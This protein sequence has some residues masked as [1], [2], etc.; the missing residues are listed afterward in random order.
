MEYRKRG[1][2]V[3]L[4][5]GNNAEKAWRDVLNK[6]RVIAEKLFPS[7][8]FDVWGEY[9]RTVNSLRFGI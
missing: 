7:A 8:G 9:S 5:M 3:T 4:L 6:E 1:G 2:A